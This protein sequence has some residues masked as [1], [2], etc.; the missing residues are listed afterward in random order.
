MFTIA[1]IWKETKCLST[2]KWI[3]KMW[4]HS[5]ITNDDILPFATM[6][7]EL[8]LIMLKEIS[9]AQKDRHH[10]LSLISGV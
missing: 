5:A 1:K 2:E 10:I 8:D 3:M 9:Q 4:Y 7:I 6:W